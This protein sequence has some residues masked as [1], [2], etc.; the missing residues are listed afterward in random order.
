MRPR[1]SSSVSL[2][3]RRYS[4]NDLPHGYALLIVACI[5]TPRDSHH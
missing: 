3:I 5:D 4:S 2:N 1:T